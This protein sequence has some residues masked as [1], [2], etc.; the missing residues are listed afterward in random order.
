MVWAHCVI[1]EWSLPTLW[2][3]RSWQELPVEWSLPTLWH[4]R[5]WQE[6]PA[7]QLYP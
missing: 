7:P 1:L 5:S 6:L 3:S 2:H 4:G